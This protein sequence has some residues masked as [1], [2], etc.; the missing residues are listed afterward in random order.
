MNNGALRVLK[1][2]TNENKLIKL[3]QKFLSHSYQELCTFE[4]VS[5]QNIQV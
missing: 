3:K 4:N 2:E 5:I 1:K